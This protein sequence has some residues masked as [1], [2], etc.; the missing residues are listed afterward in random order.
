MC[1]NSS[2]LE[3][4]TSIYYKVE[5][6]TDQ[7]RVFQ[8][9]R[10]YVSLTPGQGGQ[11][12]SQAP[13]LQVTGRTPGIKP[14]L[15]S[16]CWRMAQL[17][18]PPADQRTDDMPG[19]FG[20]FRGET[21]DFIIVKAQI[22][23]EGKPQFQFLL[24][25]AA[26]LRAIA[27]NWTMFSAYARE[28]IPQYAAPRTDLPPFTLDPPDP[29]D[30]D[31]Q[32]DDLLTLMTYCK[33]NL[34]TVEGILAGLVEA[35]GIGI[36]N[37][38]LSLADRLRFIQALLTLLPIPA[39]VG[40]TFA[41][42]VIDS[43]QT[44]TQIK[45]LA[46][47]V[48]PER[49]LIFD[50]AQGKLLNDPPE[51]VYAKFM[52][53]QFRLDTSLVVD[54]TEKLARTAVWRAMRKDDMANALAWVSRRASLD[55]A[56]QEGLPADRAMVA[57]VLR[58]DPTLPDDLRV[59][60]T[61]HLVKLALALNDPMH[62][63]VVPLMTTTNHELGNTIY[64]QLKAAIDTDQV[65]AVYNMV[66]RWITQPPSGSD[67]TRWKPLLGMAIQ[68]ETTRLLLGDNFTLR[69]FLEKFLDVAPAL[70]LEQ[71]LMQITAISRK[72]GHD[73]ADTAKVIFLLAAK[74][75]PAGSLQRLMDEKPLVDQLPEG[76]RT[77]LSHLTEK[78]ER[79]AP[80]GLFI[81]ASEVFG[82]EYEQ[83]I[84]ARL[85][86]WALFIQRFDLIDSETVRGVIKLA[87]SGKFDNMIGHLIE[88]ISAPNIVRTLEPKM[89]PL[90]VEL[91]FASNRHAYAVRLMEMYQSTLYRGT[92]NEDMAGLTRVI[93]RELPISPVQLNQALDAMQDSQLKTVTRAQAYIGALEN[94]SWGKDVEFA[95]R[96]L[97]ALIFADPRITEVIG[98][99]PVLRLLKSNAER[100]DAVESLR[101]ANALVE[102]ALL[103]APDKGPDLMQQVYPL[104]S[105]NN[106]VKEASVEVLRTYVRR[107]PLELA[108]KLPDILGGKYGDEVR[109]ALDAA[110]RLR[111]MIG[112]DNLV[113]FAE[114][115]RLGMLLL[116]DMALIYAPGREAP[117]TFK[118]RRAVEGL[119]GGL[120]DAERDRLS[121][122]LNQ[123][124]LHLLKLNQII[125][126]RKVRPE[127]EAYRGQLVKTQIP[128][129]TGI[130]ALMWIGGRFSGGKL[131]PLDL[132]TEA[133][134]HM[135]G[136]RS[137]N[138]LLRETDVLVK[139]L[140]GLINS[141]PEKEPAPLDNLTWT[142]E[143]NT[144]WGLLSLYKQRQ[145][146]QILAEDTQ[147]LS[148]LI[149]A[150]G[151][152]GNERSF[153]NTGQGKQ[154]HTGRAQPAT[155]TDALRWVSGYFGRM[156]QA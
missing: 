12:S 47:D 90:L 143:V 52:M 83:L 70:E 86:E 68:A 122:N 135:F 85:V 128:P 4:I 64:D 31:T 29:P 11:S 18:P 96:K 94:K 93:F 17:M 82:A 155:V 154:L 32:T 118:L 1:Y 84:L 58:E 10:L 111:L 106:E 59:V 9:E 97:T 61:Q 87:P 100:Q 49:H 148:Q 38:P 44:N 79:S 123:I 103:L 129:T 107:A 147:I 65:M 62:T 76:L 46:S 28:P 146:Q 22:G 6:L 19:S 37:A 51:D 16:E 43:A 23:S 131:F 81:K 53:S 156:H 34:K 24:A 115:V 152:K 30:K 77:A 25:P 57:G 95:A 33:N 20:I 2:Y 141:F 99:D 140:E 104:L 130:D 75:F 15:L 109:H 3:P 112:G 101:L 78:R 48:R 21:V 117:Q 137:V 54:Q 71:T 41:T 56:V 60:Y 144:V 136:S 74:Y 91:C 125:K 116:M 134:A 7:T 5:K 127:S 139:L 63:E 153:Q 105:W 102:Y 40:I 126:T 8:L 151:S 66:E 92:P 110:Q 88:S 98:I 13:A 73:D 27:G 149:V 142:R 145:I 67:I 89:P 55:S 42:S 113:E 108:N 39:R 35:M 36:I 124:G 14:E 133:P 26:A 119:P 138:I 132:E 45:F 114:Q 150:I 72:K 50:W 69:K 120:T 121:W 80:V